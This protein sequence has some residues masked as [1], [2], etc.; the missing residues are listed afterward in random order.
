MNKYPKQSQKKDKQNSFWNNVFNNE[1]KK[2]SN[3]S[4]RPKFTKSK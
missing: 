1:E 3:R 2:R 4:G